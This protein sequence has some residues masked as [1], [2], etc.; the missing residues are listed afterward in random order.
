VQLLG[1]ADPKMLR[2]IAQTL[3]AMGVKE[4]LVVHGSG[5][6]EVALHGETR[7]LRL[8]GNDIEELQIAP[9][10]AGIERAPLN[11]VTGGDVDENARRLTLLLAGRTR[12][13]E[14]DIVALNTAALLLT[15]GKAATLREG[16]DMA[17]DALMSGRAGQALDR[18]VEASRA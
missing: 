4:A 11:V 14:Q 9:E 15:A 17:R 12:G 3:A 1:V 10:D 8:S 7:A 2:R 6:D 18:F 5:L 13:P 16:A